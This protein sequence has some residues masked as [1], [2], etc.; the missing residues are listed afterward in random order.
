MT[1]QEIPRGPIRPG[2]LDAIHIHPSAK[3]EKCVR[4]YIVLGT[5]CIH[6]Q[7]RRVNFGSLL[8]FLDIDSPRSDVDCNDFA[9]LFA[10]LADH[11]SGANIGFLFL[12]AI[13][14]RGNPSQH[15]DS[16]DIF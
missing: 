13:A 15:F 16:P 14:I 10:A 1:Q 5:S 11:V 7:R 8:H 12:E 6:E 4:Q 3:P 9:D 2:G